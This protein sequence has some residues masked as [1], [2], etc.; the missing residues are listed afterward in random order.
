MV[1]PP[2]RLFSDKEVSP[3]EQWYTL[4]TNPN[5]EYQVVAALQQ[6]QIETYLP[7]LLSLKANK[8]KGK[9]PFFPCYL[10]ARIDFE[11]GGFVTV[12]WTPACAASS[13]LTTC[14]PPS[15]PN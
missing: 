8:G 3:M 13:A 7:E 11:Q 1:L 4:Y 15:R 6:R 9:Q 2:P 10:F 14:R 12:R 5:A